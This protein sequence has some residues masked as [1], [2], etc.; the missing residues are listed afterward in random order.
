MYMEVKRRVLPLDLIRHSR[1]VVD[2][3]HNLRRL[4]HFSRGGSHVAHIGNAGRGY[5][6]CRQVHAGKVSQ[7]PSG[8]TPCCCATRCEKCAIVVV[9]ITQRATHSLMANVSASI[10]LSPDRTCTPAHNCCCCC[11]CCCRGCSSPPPSNA[12]CWSHC[13]RLLSI[14]SRALCTVQGEKTCYIRVIGCN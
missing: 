13:S 8:G 7:K 6:H 3:E 4:L 1:R 12:T 5:R 2:R 10:A 14:Q 11:C 9:T